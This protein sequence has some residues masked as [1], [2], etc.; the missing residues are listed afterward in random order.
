MELEER[1]EKDLE[2]WNGIYRNTRKSEKFNFGANE[3][4]EG[5]LGRTGQPACIYNIYGW[6]GAWPFLHCSS[7]YRGLNLTTKSRRIRSDDVDTVSRL[8]SLSNSCY[9]ELL[10][11]V[12]GMFS[13]TYKVDN[14]HTMLWI[15]L[16]QLVERFHYPQAESVL[17]DVVKGE[18]MGDV[19]YFWACL[20]MDGSVNGTN[21]VVTFWTMCD[22]LNGGSCREAFKLAFRKMYKLPPHIE[23]LPPMPDDGG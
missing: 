13:M 8:N 5:E 14:I 15:G 10:C 19:L 20:E 21:D 6:T 16:V 11:E 12:G 7:L 17:E 18:T 2:S 9:Q 1:M 22:M 3:R 23:A 4:D